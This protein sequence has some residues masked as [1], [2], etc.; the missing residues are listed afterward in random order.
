ML[1]PILLSPMGRYAAA[2][3]GSSIDP[4]DLKNW[5]R[6]HLGFGTSDICALGFSSMKGSIFHYFQDRKKFL[7]KLADKAI[8]LT[9]ID[10]KP[11]TSKSGVAV[12][13][14]SSKFYRKFLRNDAGYYDWL[15]EYLRKKLSRRL[16]LSFLE[17]EDMKEV[18]LSILMSGVHSPIIEAICEK[19]GFEM[20][21]EGSLGEKIR[22]FNDE[23]VDKSVKE[24]IKKGIEERIKIML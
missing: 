17:F 16:K 18:Y 23:K 4:A 5:T 2:G 8:K 7:Q 12:L 14:S 3:F 24:E 11:E 22:R 21:G 13:S 19:A 9:T 10:C 6:T 15:V 20:T 1:S